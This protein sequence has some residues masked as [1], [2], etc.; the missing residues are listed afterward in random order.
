MWR[1]VPRHRL[2]QSPPALF[3]FLPCSATP[4]TAATPNTGKQSVQGKVKK[5]KKCMGRPAREARWP[6]HAFFGEI[7][8]R[9]KLKRPLARSRLCLGR[10]VPGSNAEWG[11]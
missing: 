10:R 8:E 9:W 7:F 6:P 1:Y 3:A 5:S 4:A 11:V 2:E